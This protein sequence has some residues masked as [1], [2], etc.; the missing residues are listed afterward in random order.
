M[1]RVIVV[2]LTGHAR[3]FTLHEDAYA[4]LER[5]LNDARARLG[6]DPDSAEVLGDLERAIGEHLTSVAGPADRVIESADVAAVV[7]EIGAVDLGREAPAIGST[8]GQ[9]GWTP[10]AAGPGPIAGRAPGARRLY[11]IREGQNIAGVCNGLA[12]YS[13]LDVGLVRVIFVLLAIFTAGAFVIAYLVLM[14]VLPVVG[15]RDEWLAMSGG[16]G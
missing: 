3:R 5:Y 2:E 4:T 1:H 8:P 12:A 6:D 16:P 14:F 11:R 13:D 15:T 10:P 9:A 7:E